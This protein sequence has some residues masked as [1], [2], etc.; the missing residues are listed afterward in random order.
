MQKK[1]REFQRIAVLVDVQNLYYSAKF[2][3]HSK[4]NYSKLLE[5]AVNDRQLIRAVAYTI[6]NPETDQSGFTDILV[7]L[8]FE[9]KSK[10]LKVRADQSMKG[11]WDMGIAI[12]AIGLAERLDVI[13]LVSGDGDYEDLLHMLKSRGVK[14]EVVSFPKSTAKELIEAA[15]EYRPI[16]KDILIHAR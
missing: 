3:Y 4:V 12:D 11:D 14:V 16:E 8:G 7:D 5:F 1:Y 6:Y 13:V 9:V 2:Q 15:S 10:A